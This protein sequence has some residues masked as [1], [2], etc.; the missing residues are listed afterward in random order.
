MVRRLLWP[1]RIHVNGD[2]YCS[3][4]HLFRYIPVT[5]TMVRLRSWEVCSAKYRGQPEAGLGLWASR[6]VE[7]RHRMCV[8]WVVF[9]KFGICFTYHEPTSSF[10]FR[11]Y[12]GLLTS[13]CMFAHN[14]WEQSCSLYADR[15]VVHQNLAG[16]ITLHILAYLLWLK[17]MD[18]GKRSTSHKDCHRPMDISS[19]RLSIAFVLVLAGIFWQ[20][21]SRF[22]LDTPFPTIRT[23]MTYEKTLPQTLSLLY[24]EG[25]PDVATGDEIWCRPGIRNRV[26]ARCVGAI[27]ATQRTFEFSRM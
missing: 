12:Q 18:L 22:C 5:E 3:D 24:I 2:C 21:A 15:S 19:V 20:L 23:I 14:L 16:I 4:S 6:R 25:P 17:V 10:L 8:C 13:S 7:S 11:D 26:W 9:T 27:V 1:T